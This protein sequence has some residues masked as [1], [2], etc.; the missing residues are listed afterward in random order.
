MLFFVC[1]VSSL[2][3]MLRLFGEKGQLLQ[4]AAH[5]WVAWLFCKWWFTD[6]QRTLIAGVLLTILEVA[7]FF[8]LRISNPLPCITG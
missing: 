2:L 3:G 5:F 8:G 4:A 7:C 6:D 1:T